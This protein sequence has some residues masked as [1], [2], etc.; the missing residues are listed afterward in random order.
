MLDDVGLLETSRI[1]VGTH[2][3]F[4]L[5][6]TVWFPRSVRKG[7]VLERSCI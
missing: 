1:Q 3:A 2:I 5:K 7:D 4:H 6:Q